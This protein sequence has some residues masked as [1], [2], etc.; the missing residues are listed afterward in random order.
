MPSLERHLKVWE[1]WRD[2]NFFNCK[3][4][5]SPTCQIYHDWI[6]VF[7]DNLH[8]SQTAAFLLL[9]T[10]PLSVKIAQCAVSTI[11]LLLLILNHLLHNLSPTSHRHH[12]RQCKWWLLSSKRNTSSKNWP[13]RLRYICCSRLWLLHCILLHC[14]PLI[15]WIWQAQEP[16]Y[17]F[18]TGNGTRT[19]RRRVCF[20]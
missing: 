13:E 14:R 1:R 16:R 11:L 10:K 5:E 17:H 4:T 12:A 7:T 20:E 6:I 19:K 8:S 15:V 3:A 2:F 9:L 18:N